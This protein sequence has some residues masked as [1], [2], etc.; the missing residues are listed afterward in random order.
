MP[1]IPMPKPYRDDVTTI[2]PKDSKSWPG[3]NKANET[4]GSK[5]SE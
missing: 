1:D 4:Q 3:S 5:K 2:T